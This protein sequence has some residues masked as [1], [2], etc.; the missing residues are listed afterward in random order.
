MA[1]A[2]K[3]TAPHLAVSELA[4]GRGLDEVTGTR[5]YREGTGNRKNPSCCNLQAE[6][7][8]FMIATTAPERRRLEPVIPIARVLQQRAG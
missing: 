3:E 7:N 5:H 8:E 6:D 2:K 1:S 4:G